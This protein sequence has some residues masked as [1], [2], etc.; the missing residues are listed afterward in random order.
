MFKATQIVMVS[1]LVQGTR[2]RCHRFYL[3][4]YGEKII[5]LVFVCWA[6]CKTKQA[7][8]GRALKIYLLRKK[9]MRSCVTLL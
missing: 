3:L 8:A 1:R 7:S 6:P 9:S 4:G 2:A 5:K